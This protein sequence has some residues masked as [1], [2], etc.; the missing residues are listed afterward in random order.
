[1][2]ALAVFAPDAP[3]LT[4]LATFLEEQRHGISRRLRAEGERPAVRGRT[5]GA[6]WQLLEREGRYIAAPLTEAAR[7]CAAL[8]E[9]WQ[10]PRLAD[11]DRLTPAPDEPSTLNVWV[12]TDDGPAHRASSA[13]IVSGSWR[14]TGFVA[15]AEPGRDHFHVLCVRPDER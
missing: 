15:S 2:T 5:S 13:Q 3:I 12:R 8:G 1:M 10:T 11:L 14:P 6:N 4:R 9:G 7:L